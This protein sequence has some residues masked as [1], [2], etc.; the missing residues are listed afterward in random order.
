M[1]ALLLYIR[2][3]IS[4]CWGRDIFQSAC[5]RLLVIFWKFSE[6]TFFL[7]ISII[8]TCCVLLWLQ[9]CG[10]YGTW[11]VVTHIL[12]SEPTNSAVLYTAQHLLLLRHRNLPAGTAVYQP[13]WFIGRDIPDSSFWNLVGTGLCWISEHVCLLKDPHS[14]MFHSV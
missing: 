4:S 8:Y 2:M 11:Q 12:L 5:C 3:C 1:Y 13:L 9:G 7:K 6:R 10:E 14:C